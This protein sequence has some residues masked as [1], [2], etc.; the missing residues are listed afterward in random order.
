[1]EVACGE[2]V[3]TMKEEFPFMK[4]MKPAE[5]SFYVCFGVG[6][7]ESSLLT[8]NCEIGKKSLEAMK[9]NVNRR[10]QEATTDNDRWY[11]EKLILLLSILENAS[12][13]DALDYLQYY[14]TTNDGYLLLAIG[15]WI[16]ALINHDFL[17]DQIK[18]ISQSEIDIL[19]E[20]LC[21]YV[22]IVSEEGNIWTE[23]S[24]LM[25]SVHLFKASQNTFCEYSILYH[26]SFLTLDRSEAHVLNYYPFCVKHTEN[27]TIP[28]LKPVFNLFDTILTVLKDKSLPNQAVLKLKNSLKA[29]EEKT[30]VISAFLEDIDEE[31]E[32]E[33]Q[34]NFLQPFSDPEKLCFTCEKP[35]LNTFPL[36][37]QCAEH[38][39]CI[40]CIVTAYKDSLQ[41][42]C[43]FCSR[44]YS[45]CELSLIH[46]F[47]NP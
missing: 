43:H 46:S 12:Y 5:K 4:K 18:I 29:L 28:S 15:M 14:V 36:L 30:P 17:D 25:P 24:D 19:S 27:D 20:K 7:L 40:R 41:S 33:K 2:T 34:F 44:E 9:N 21:L 1:M 38:H 31:K 32:L 35:L 45:D 11:A 26:R 13:S 10:Q 8:S 3:E 23:C 42:S 22:C 37:L 47:A 39:N 16:A 6:A